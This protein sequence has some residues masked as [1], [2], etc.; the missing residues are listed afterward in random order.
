MV[1]R[2][3]VAYFSIKCLLKVEMEAINRLKR[4]R[5]KQGT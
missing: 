5:N 1:A 2:L 4:E 3:T